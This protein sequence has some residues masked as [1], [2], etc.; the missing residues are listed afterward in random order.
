MNICC[1]GICMFTKWMIL[2]GSSENELG[3][4]YDSTVSHYRTLQF[5]SE[6]WDVHSEKKFCRCDMITV[7]VRTGHVSL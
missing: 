6:S 3:K 5:C 7:L 1:Y 4:S 2:A